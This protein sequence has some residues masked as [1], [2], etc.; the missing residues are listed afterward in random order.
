MKKKAILFCA[1]MFGA[2]AAALAIQPAPAKDAKA[3][4]L[5][6]KLQARIASMGDYR[7][8]FKVYAEGNPV[9]GVF[10]VSG[11]KFRIVSDG[12]DVIGDGKVRYE[13]NHGMAEVAIDN[14]DSTDINILTNP[15]RAFEFASVGFEP[16]YEGEVTVN[17]I[18]CD[19]IYL[20][21]SG[22]NVTITGVMLAVSRAT[23]LPVRMIYG[24]DG[25]ED[26]VMVS[27][28]KFEGGLHIPSA[29]FRFDRT[30]YKDYE[31]VDFR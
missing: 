10:N 1:I 20:T 23:G 31:V 15:T 6:S 24:L 4:E 7:I 19:Q 13:I 22:N 3:Q 30:K 14:M 8:T 26:E 9:E 5:L 16:V 18:K 11:R 17:G 21:P 28:V 2:V 12:F 29:D 27:I 25:I